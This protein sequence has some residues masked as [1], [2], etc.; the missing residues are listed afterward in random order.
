MGWG[1]DYAGDL[2]NI[3]SQVAGLEQDYDNAIAELEEVQNEL[4]ELKKYIEWAEKFYP[5]MANQ[6]GAI[7][8]VRGDLNK[9]NQNDWE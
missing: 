2:Q 6:Y 3:A 4:D 5:E 1:N 7:C 9:E 8:A